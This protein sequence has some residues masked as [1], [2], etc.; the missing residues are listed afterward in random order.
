MKRKAYGRDTG[1]TLR[2]LF[3]GGLLGLVY[4]V[5]RALPL[6][7]LHAASSGVVIVAALAVFQYFTSAKLALLAAGAKI[8]EPGR[9]ARAARHDRAPVRDGRPAEAEGGSH[10]QPTCRTRS[11]RA[12]TR[13]TPPSPSPP[14]SGDA[15]A[16]GDRG[17]ARARAV[18][19]RQP[20]RADHDAGQLLRAAR[21]PDHPLRPL[22]R[23]LGRLR[24]QQP[25]QQQRAAGVAGRP[26]RLGRH[27]RRSATSSSAPSPATASTRQTAARR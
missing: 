24:R 7:R 15:G 3:T 22:R 13:S 21:R 8:V 1:L 25:R 6:L 4:V 26:A 27:L 20:R 11:R 23:A 12:A 16:A 2:L 18:A 19:H 17:R 14:A 5:L 10:R 9:G